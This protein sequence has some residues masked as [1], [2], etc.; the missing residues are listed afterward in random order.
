MRL[1]D[2]PPDLQRR[3]RATVL[4]PKTKRRTPVDGADALAVALDA[5]QLVGFAREHKFHVKRQWR[6]DI[7]YPMQRLAVEVE[8]FAPRGKAGRHQRPAGFAEDCEKYAELAIA[9]WR[10][11]RVTTRQV[12]S[13]AAVQWITRA[14]T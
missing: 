5:A 10:L 14:L 13:G 7:A 4:V 12:R 2:L 9:G 1:D 8:G 3:V 11:I 6:V